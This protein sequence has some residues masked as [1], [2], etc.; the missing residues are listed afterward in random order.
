MLAKALRERPELA[1]SIQARFDP[2]GDS[3]ALKEQKIRR[4]VAIRRGTRPKRGEEPEPVSFNDTKSQAAL[5]QLFSRRVSPAALARLKQQFAQA[6][7]PPTER[8][9]MPTAKPPATDGNSISGLY[10]AIYDELIKTAEVSQMELIILGSKRARA[11]QHRLTGAGGIAAARVSV[12][13]PVK[14]KSGSVKD[15]GVITRLELA[16]AR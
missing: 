5:E 7:K 16:A 3:R 11:I 8:H 10:K 2:Q 13:Q 1:V 4:A 6:Q 15:T 14:A 9:K 12:P